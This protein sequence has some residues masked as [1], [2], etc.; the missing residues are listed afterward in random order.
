MQSVW[1]WLVAIYLFLG[2]LGAGAFLVA[3]TLELSGKRYKFDFCPTTLVGATLSGPLVGIGALLLVFDLGA[4][5]REPV[6][7]FHMFANGSSVMTWGIWILSCFI[8]LA[9]VYGLLEVIDTFRKGGK[10]PAGRLPVR[11]IK[12]IVAAIGSVFAVGTALYTGVL[13]SAVGPS[14]P[15]WSTPLLPSLSIPV[16]PLLFLVSALSTGVALTVLL[17]GTLVVGD[18]QKQLRRF[19]VVHLVLILLEVALMALLLTTAL[20]QGGA[21]AQAT[22]ALASGS[23]SPI[24]WALFVVPGLAIPLVTL[25]LGVAGVH[26]RSLELVEGICILAAGLVLRYLVL[27]SAIPV[28]L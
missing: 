12:R 17:S 10:E 3:A 13:L 24:F 25:A 11:T 20:G 23:N 16:L 18:V 9:L 28:P 22:Q 15:F 27:I 6:R 5:M 14:M 2:G 7:I 19:P 8:P 1:G 21:A 4:G 26:W